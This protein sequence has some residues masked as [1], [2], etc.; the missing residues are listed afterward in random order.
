MVLFSNLNEKQIESSGQTCFEPEPPSSSRL[1]VPKAPSSVVFKSNSGSN[2]IK[3]MVNVQGKKL[4]LMELSAKV[5]DLADK[6]V[7]FYS[8]CGGR[9]PSVKLEDQNGCEL[10]FDD[11]LTDVFIVPQV[12]PFKHFSKVLIRQC[13]CSKEYWLVSSKSI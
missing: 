4:V 2:R 13:S 10:G 1:T 3:F 8:K 9:M 6:I 11:N 7:D 12:W 5:K